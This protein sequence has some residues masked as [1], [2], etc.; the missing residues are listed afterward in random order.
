MARLEWIFEVFIA[1]PSD[2]AR[3][4]RIVAE[5]I[6]RINAKYD[7][8]SLKPVMWERD[9]L[10]A[11]NEPD[12][13]AK[14]NTMLGR[15]DLMIAVFGGIMGTP[16]ARTAGGAIEE[17]QEFDGDVYLYLKDSNERRLFDEL[18]PHFDRMRNRVYET[19]DG[20]QDLKD[21]V[22]LAI[23]RWFNRQIVKV[24][25]LNDAG[26]Q[27]V[28][29]DHTSSPAPRTDDMDQEKPVDSDSSAT[30][31]EAVPEQIVQ[32]PVSRQPARQSIRGSVADLL[33]EG[34][35]AAGSR[36]ICEPRPGERYNATV[37]A[38]GDIQLPDGRTF[39]SLSGAGKAVAGRSFS[40]W[41]GWWT[42]DGRTLYELRSELQFASDHQT[43]ATGAVPQAESVDP[44]SSEIASEGMP[45]APVSQQ[46]ASS[47]G[48][49]KKMIRGSVADLLRE[50][51]LAVSA[52]IICEPRPGEQYTATV[53]A[54][55]DIQVPDGRTFNSLSAAETVVAG[56]KPRGWTGWRTEDG[57]TLHQ[58]RSELQF[59]SGIRLRTIR[60]SVADLLSQGLL[61]AGVQIISEPRPGERY[62]ATVL[63]SGDIQL[64][65]GR[66]FS[67][68][69][70]AGK[71]VSGREV[72]GWQVW[73]TED[74]RTLY[75]LRSELQFASD[76]QTHATGAVP[77]AESVDPVSSEIASEGMPT[78]P[79]SQQPASS[80]GARKKMIRG[81][82]ADLLREGLLAV[83]AQI[84][85]EPRP[86]ER[87]TATVL[88][89]GDIQLPDGRTF[90]SLSGAGEA[91]AG[92]RFSG[93]EGWWTEDGR[94]LHE[95]RS[96]L[97]FASEFRRRTIRGSVA[98]LLR[99]GLLA[100]GAQI[101]CEPRPGD[102]YNATVLASGN[103]QL[104]DG[105]TF[106][107]PSAAGEAVAGRKFSG[108][109]EW[110]TE[111]GRTLHELRSRL[112]E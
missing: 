17:I 80:Q 11:F 91:V 104:P 12:T 97:Q 65:D 90:S 68:L 61:A 15:C 73:R 5:I 38:S 58:L 13:Q 83:S 49:R 99:G 105:R 45:T 69:S 54:S 36:I 107:N 21:K 72:S 32:Q 50:G 100:V 79:V 34:L 22:D 56:H 103:I 51:L 23:S 112:P 77:Q 27:A 40:G 81:S 102:R 10:R 3:E 8:Y 108:W 84:I 6:E 74:G 57:Q 28:G 43:H 96:R 95:L 89:S 110:R 44:V 82:V 59:A 70:G 46:P 111:D 2:V 7:D 24:G 85:C 66:T 98:D 31:I 93:W 16:T 9:Y 60:G 30:G 52:Q 67:S 87:Y 55:G 39:S 64:P 92:R 37:L 86:G 41:D 42:E 78:A 62:T 25:V 71:A 94:T 48:A 63:A 88:A 29:Q 35:L 109:K 20:E 106:N 18:E 101:I 19:Y 14:I 76:H 33:R 1:S 53:L 4:R 26:L 47:Q 75:E